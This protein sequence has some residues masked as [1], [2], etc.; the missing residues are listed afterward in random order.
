MSFPGE[1]PEDTEEP[2]GGYPPPVQA[3]GGDRPRKALKEEYVSPEW[4]AWREGTLNGLRPQPPVECGRFFFLF[5]LDCLTLKSTQYHRRAGLSIHVRA[6]MDEETGA[7]RRH[8]AERPLERR[9]TAREDIDVRIQL[10]LARKSC[11][12]FIEE[13]RTGLAAGHHLGSVT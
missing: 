7:R 10:D 5:N 1:F 3:A 9:H 6:N 2:L 11:Q 12:H 8:V 13:L 4:K